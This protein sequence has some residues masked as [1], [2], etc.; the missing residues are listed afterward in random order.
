VGRAR[1]GGDSFCHPIL[2]AFFRNPPFRDAR[3]RCNPLLPVQLPLQPPPRSCAC[4]RSLDRSSLRA[5]RAAHHYT[6]MTTTINQISLLYWYTF[7]IR[8]QLTRSQGY[9]YLW[10]THINEN[11]KRDVNTNAKD[12]VPTVPSPPNSSIRLWCFSSFNAFLWSTVSA[13]SAPYISALWG[14]CSSPSSLRWNRWWCCFSWDIFFKHR[15]E[16]RVAL[17]ILTRINR[18]GLTE[19]NPDEMWEMRYIGVV[20]VGGVGG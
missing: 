12:M 18:N 3:G 1:R 8:I 4:G 11:K 10:S 13:F 20:Y 6:Y 14:T 17:T 19:Q 2:F 16:S 15:L 5:S 7:P 9:Y